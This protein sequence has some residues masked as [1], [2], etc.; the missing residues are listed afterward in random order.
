[1]SARK[2]KSVVE[3][4]S[5]AVTW[6]APTEHEFRDLRRYNVW[7]AH[8]SN[9]PPRPTHNGNQQPLSKKPRHSV[10]GHDAVA[11]EPHPVGPIAALNEEV[12]VDPNWQAGLWIGKIVEIR[13]KDTSYVWT[14]IRW[15]CQSI[16]ELKES[17]IRTG[18][19]RSKGDSRE[20]FMLGS[21]HDAL[22][23][24]GAVEA[25]APVILFDERNPLQAPFGNKSIF[26]R[27]EARTPTP[28]EV[29]K[30]VPKKIAGDVEPKSRKKGRASEAPS[31]GHLFPIRKPTC[32][33]GDPYRPLS[34]R[35]EPMAL[36]SHLG[37]LRWFHLGCL[38]WK[39]D[40]RRTATPSSLE[41]VRNSG[42][43][44]M[45][46]L[47]QY[48]LTTPAKEISLEHDPSDLN[49]TW[50]DS[51]TNQEAEIESCGILAEDIKDEGIGAVPQLTAM[52]VEQNAF[53][54]KYLPDSIL[55]AAE[56]PIERGSTDTGIVGNARYV[57]RAR[58][59]LQKNREVRRRSQ[60]EPVEV[61][62]IEKMVLEWENIWK[63]KREEQVYQRRSVVWLCPG[64]RRAM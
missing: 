50:P 34:E 57:M 9:K 48:G 62:R 2:R 40:H 13:A 59:I 45:S 56:S 54:D 51:T 15:M 52:T 46:L 53:L 3:E 29:E 43:E 24:V 17:G 38:D 63:I 18:L 6:V 47:P 39:N 25:T 33:C 7:L 27:S 42:V 19:P 4:S 36:C 41:D 23:P 22:Q 1:M 32:Y 11:E 28:A 12:E 21:E 60:V 37:C 14:K 30:L 31:G 44:L 55:L 35:E 61:E 5:P 49:F 20:I 8:E 16:G 26:F 58:E 10:S 64:C